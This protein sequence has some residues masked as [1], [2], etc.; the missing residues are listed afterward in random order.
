MLDNWL[1]G[2]HNFLVSV[3]VVC[4]YCSTCT[5]IAAGKEGLFCSVGRRQLTMGAHNWLRIFLPILEDLVG[6]F[7]YVVL[8]CVYLTCVLLRFLLAMFSS[9]NQWWLSL[10][11]TSR[12]DRNSGH[13]ICMTFL[14]FWV[15]LFYTHLQPWFGADELVASAL[16]LI[17]AV[18][19]EG[20]MLCCNTKYTSK[21]GATALMFSTL[22]GA[23]DWQNEFWLKLLE[24]NKYAKNVI[25]KLIS[26][27]MNKNL[28]CFP[29]LICVFSP[30]G[31]NV[32]V[33][34]ENANR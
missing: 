2:A 34:V 25:N 32:M 28:K 16:Q 15:I 10:P 26:N 21:V 8:Y 30:L 29:L 19:N 20:V 24:V 18:H 6:K 27:Q 4:D 17:I 5:C 14:K 22:L 3:T 7:S 31:P 1:Y 23:K 11:I 12:C 33:W 13:K 9:A